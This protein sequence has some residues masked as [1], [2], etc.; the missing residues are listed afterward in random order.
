VDAFIAAWGEQNESFPEH[1]DLENLSQVL[2]QP[3]SALIVRRLP[4]T[5]AWIERQHRKH[6][7]EAQAVIV[8]YQTDGMISTRIKKF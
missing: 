2:A 3:P 1:S 5:Y 6:H 8:H 7:R 4:V